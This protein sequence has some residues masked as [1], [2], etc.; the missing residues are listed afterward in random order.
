VPAAIAGVV[1]Q[2]VGVS[3]RNEALLA[4]ISEINLELLRRRALG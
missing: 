1:E 4:E 2:Q 3:Q